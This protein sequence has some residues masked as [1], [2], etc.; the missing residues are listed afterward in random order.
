MS[1]NT[2]KI[3]MFGWKRSG[4]NTIWE[5]SVFYIQTLENIKG[6]SKNDNL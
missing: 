6:Q 3:I 4:P 1:N 5:K 2:G